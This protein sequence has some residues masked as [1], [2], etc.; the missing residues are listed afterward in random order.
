MSSL[1]ELDLDND[2]KLI[3]TYLKRWRRYALS[4]HI[5]A[6]Q[7]DKF[8]YPTLQQYELCKLRDRHRYIAVAASRG[9]GKTAWICAET[10]RHLVCFR[11]AGI[12]VKVPITGPSGGQL[13]DVSWAE[14]DSTLTRLLPWL[15]N[16]FELT[17][18]S[19]YC[20]EL[21]K[22]WFASPR[23]AKK[24]NPGSLQG[25]HG[26]TLNIYDEGSHIPDEIFNVSLAS[27]TQS[28]TYALL[29]LNPDRLSGYAYR[30][31][32]KMK[33]S[34]WTKYFID[35]YDCK[36]SQTYKYPYFPPLGGVRI[37]EVKGLVSDQWFRDQED[38][39]GEGSP[40]HDAYVRGRFPTSEMNNLIKKDWVDQAFKRMTQEETEATKKRVDVKDGIE[41]VIHI[42]HK[43]IL[44]VDPGYERD[45]TGLV[46]RKGTFYE[47][48]DHLY[49]LDPYEVAK[50]VEDIFVSMK[51]AGKPVDQIA[52][53]TI[54]IGAG[55]IA[56]LRKFGR[57]HGYLNG[58]PVVS[59]KAN[60]KAP[61]IG[62]DCKLLRDW[63]W[64]QMRAHFR[65]HRIV[66]ERKDDKME[67]LA[68]QICSLGYSH[69][70]GVI[71]VE[72]KEQLLK[73]GLPSPNLGDAAAL[74]YK[75]DNPVYS[76]VP[77]KPIDIYRRKKRRRK[78][79]SWLTV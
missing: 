3:A 78:K 22:N 29:A 55:V 37:I 10:I 32:N 74:T 11:I 70:K 14:I 48:A 65:D 25:Q 50:Q 27:M 64:W 31:F 61:K 49:G 26:S 67:L 15:R 20:K 5:E 24:E 4:F 2:C 75:I 1:T 40:L 21:P 17:A 9:V 73:R 38:E 71:M 47:Y 68:E 79:S 57:E 46:I 51:A 56:N 44:A 60:E 77:L 34:R 59:V 76:R 42:R 13:D 19:L 43:R 54:G 52:I 23:T 72:T 53:D 45:P 7:A 18:E 16:R 58:Y 66:F 33:R 12:P 28:H 30:V 36:E 62:A 41:R 69:P 6:L 39:L 35:G 63:L 8:W